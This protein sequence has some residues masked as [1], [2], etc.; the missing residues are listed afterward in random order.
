MNIIRRFLCILALVGFPLS[1]LFAQQSILVASSNDSSAS[2]SVSWSVGLVAFSAVTGTT[3]S[4]LEGVQ[5]P[6]EIY[7]V[8]GIG[9]NEKGPQCA[10]YPNPATEQITLRFL[11]SNL[12]DYTVQLFNMQGTLLKNLKADSREITIPLGDVAPSSLFL[13]IFEN[14]KPVK[15]FKIIKK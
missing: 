8:D 2:G 5:Q 4:L 12:K 14:A 10:L 11:E 9:E 7:I 3:G 15:N 1:G 6:Y 13:V